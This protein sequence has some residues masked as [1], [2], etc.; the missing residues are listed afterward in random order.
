MSCD[1]EKLSIPLE[2]H[3]KALSREIFL[4]FLAKKLIFYLLAN[5]T[6]TAYLN[7][8]DRGLSKDI[9]LVIG[10]PGKV[11]VHTFLG[12]SK[13]RLLSQRSCRNSKAITFLLHV[14][15]W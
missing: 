12:W 7:V 5:P 6:E 13:A 8:R 9:W 14:L 11:A 3:H 10:Q 15:S 1:K 4:S 2:A